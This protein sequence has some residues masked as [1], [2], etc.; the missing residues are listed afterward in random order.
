MHFNKNWTFL[1]ESS[2]LKIQSSLTT[3]NDKKD[4]QRRLG[5]WGWQKL[6]DEI[7]HYKKV[8]NF[9]S[10]PPWVRSF[11]EM[12]GDTY[13]MWSAIVFPELYNPNKGNELDEKQNV[14]VAE[15]L[16]R[17]VWLL[18]ASTW[19]GKTYITA[20]LI[21]NIWRKTLIIVPWLELMNQMK[22]DLEWIFGKKYKTLS[23]KSWK[24]K[25]VCEDICIANIDSL[26]KQDTSFFQMFDLCILD[27]A[28][29]YIGS[30]TRRELIWEKITCKHIYALTG[31]IKV[32]H[33]PER[34]MKIYFWYKTELL[35]KYFSPDI[36][37]VLTDFRFE[38]EDMKQF[39]TLK[40]NLYCDNERN[41]MITKVVKDT[42][43]D[44]KWTLFL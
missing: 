21:K 24:Q 31:T 11:W 32:N 37:R 29:T 34:V 40:Q 16:K 5:F 41:N 22:K 17:D 30:D 43:W 26:V 13:I 3:N 9:Y 8:W 36:F 44:R 12:S 14:A 38:I 18:H 20:K 7:K 10:V 28:D 19:I 1:D 25:D 33:I 27:E 35:E 15:L 4:H 23:S 42:L 39:H 2:F 6:P